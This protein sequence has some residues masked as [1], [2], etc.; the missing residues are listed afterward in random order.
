VGLSQR[1]SAE[2]PRL[3]LKQYPRGNNGSGNPRPKSS[4]MFRAARA[5]AKDALN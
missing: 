2:N 5:A 1:K 3:R 4:E